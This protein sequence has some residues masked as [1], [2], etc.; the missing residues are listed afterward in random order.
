[1]LGRQQEKLE[2]EVARL[3]GQEQRLAV[4]VNRVQSCQAAPA[5]TPLDE[6]CSAYDGLLR[7]APEEYTLYG[8]SAAALAQVGGAPATSCQLVLC[9]HAANMSASIGLVQGAELWSQCKLRMAA[10]GAAALDR[11]ACT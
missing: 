3:D 7:A 5:A 4:I 11:S 9:M 6:L 1:M 8:I 10:C 2:A